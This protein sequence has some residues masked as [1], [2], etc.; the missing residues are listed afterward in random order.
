[1]ADSFDFEQSRLKTQSEN[2]FISWFYGADD[3]EGNILW[4]V[5]KLHLRLWHG[6]NYTCT[7]CSPW[8]L[9]LAR[10]LLLT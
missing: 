1:M 3:T 2:F 10:L 8:Q 9:E 6:S 5:P 7:V 4:F